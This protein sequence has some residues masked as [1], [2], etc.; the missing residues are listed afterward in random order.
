MSKNNS[1]LFN[2]PE[3]DF[4]ET[5]FM[6]DNF[7]KMLNNIKR[8]NNAYSQDYSSTLPNGF[9]YNTNESNFRNLNNDSQS[10]FSKLKDND[11][12]FSKAEIGRTANNNLNSSVFERLNS[13]ST[14]SRRNKIHSS[15]ISHEPLKNLKEEKEFQECTFRPKI[16]ERKP[17]F[18]NK[19]NNLPSKQSLRLILRGIL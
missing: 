3:K 6:N 19:N 15:S 14:I 4:T 1:S 5:K 11:M 2:S 7:E 16:S 18:I 17:G 12:S 13:G 8:I 9:Y 10:N